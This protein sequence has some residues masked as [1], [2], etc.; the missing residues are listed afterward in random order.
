M[1]SQSGEE[2]GC[3][4]G[5][6]FRVWFEA[7]IRGYDSEDLWDKPQKK[8][9]MS[10]QV[11]VVRFLVS[12]PPS[13]TASSIDRS[14]PRQTQQQVAAPSSTRQQSCPFGGRTMPHPTAPSPAAPS[15]A[16]RGMHRTRPAPHGT[17]CGLQR[18]HP[19][20]QPAAPSSTQQHPAPPSRTQQLTAAPSKQHAGAW[21]VACIARVLPHMGQSVDC[22]ARTPHPSQQHPTAPSTQIHTHTHIYIYIYLFI[23]LFIY[24]Y[25][26]IYLNIF[27]YLQFNILIY[28]Y[29]YMSIFQHI[30]MYIYI[31][32]Y[33]WK[34]NIYILIYLY[35]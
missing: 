8:S 13:S 2:R 23:Y 25:I 4:S 26:C 18:T 19:T 28:L 15:G 5:V 10:G 20:T 27:I 6:W 7:M 22:S 34:K 17:E 11:K 32:I 29:I 16:G 3:D 14:G 21:D 30:Y 24:L 33:V 31:Y 9:A 12:F 35:I 1:R